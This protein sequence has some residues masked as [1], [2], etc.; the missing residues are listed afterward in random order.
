MS[1]FAPPPALLRHPAACYIHFRRPEPPL[2]PATMALAWPSLA[3]A[4]STCCSS[5]TQHACSTAFAI[6]RQQQRHL[7]QQQ[8]QQ[9]DGWRRRRRRRQPQP[10]NVVL[11]PLR[12]ALTSAAGTESDSEE[13][14]GQTVEKRLAMIKNMI[15]TSELLVPYDRSAVNL[16]LILWC[17]GCWPVTFAVG[18]CR[19]G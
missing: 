7:Q 8:Q 14:D 10:H 6:P 9:P 4:A 11:A 15:A 1:V 12:A 18:R 13:Q 5:R 3:G 19:R 16:A 2:R 17:G